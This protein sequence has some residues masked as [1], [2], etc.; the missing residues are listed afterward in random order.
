MASTIYSKDRTNKDRIFI[1][2]RGDEEASKE[3]CH[4]PNPPPPSHPWSIIPIQRELS[5][6]SRSANSPWDRWRRDS[7]SSSPCVS[8]LASGSPK[9]AGGWPPHARR[10]L[11]SFPHL[12]HFPPSPPSRSSSPSPLLPPPSKSAAQAG[13]GGVGGGRRRR[14]LLLLFLLTP[15]DWLPSPSTPAGSGGWVGWGSKKERFWG[16]GG[17]P[18]SPCPKWG[19]PPSWL[20]NHAGFLFLMWGKRK[21]RKRF[22]GGIMCRSLVLLFLAR[23]IRAKLALSPSTHG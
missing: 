9:C 19:Q 23:R 22:L 6:C 12:S 4:H 16:F 5:F 21:R 18:P 2:K 10:V 14:R 8:S 20:T 3:S 17:E 11:A 13:V 1:T 7:S 15:P